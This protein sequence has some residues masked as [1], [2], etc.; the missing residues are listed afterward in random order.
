MVIAI[1]MFLVY[2]LDLLLKTNLRK[3]LFDPAQLRLLKGTL[4]HFLLNLLEA[5]RP[6]S[7]E[8]TRCVTTTQ[9]PRQRLL[10]ISDKCIV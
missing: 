1:S 10:M 8:R 2:L 4:D 3:Q 7:Q 6:V 9:N 5:A